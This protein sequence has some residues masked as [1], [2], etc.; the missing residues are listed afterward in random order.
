MSF[1]GPHLH[2]SLQMIYLN[3]IFGIWLFQAGV[4]S[5]NLS[6]HPYSVR[7]WRV[8]LSVIC[9]VI[10]IY[11]C[12]RLAISFQCLIIVTTSFLHPSDSFHNVCWFFFFPS[13]RCIY[14]DSL[15]I[16]TK[17]KSKKVPAAQKAFD[18]CIFVRGFTCPCRN[19]MFASS[20]I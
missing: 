17:K 2:L 19:F 9:I 15:M 13:R 7:L 5:L 4:F 20:Y 14:Q 12:G 18:N 6:S 11:T 16:S 10:Y 3:Q 1:F 8:I